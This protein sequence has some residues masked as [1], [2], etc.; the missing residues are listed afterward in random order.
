MDFQSKYQSILGDPF[1][2]DQTIKE[3]NPDLYL[4]WKLQ[5]EQLKQLLIKHDEERSVASNN[6]VY[7]QRQL[8]QRTER[9][10]DDEV[11]KSGMKLG[12]F[13][14][15]LFAMTDDMELVLD[16]GQNPD[17][18]AETY[19][20]VAS[21]LANGAKYVKDI[22]IESG[23]R[24]ALVAQALLSPSFRQS[25]PQFF[26]EV[27]VSDS[28]ES[29]HI[30][31]LQRG[32]TQ[33]Q[34]ERALSAL[35]QEEMSDEEFVA[36][37][38]N[39]L[40]RNPQLSLEPGGKSG[41]LTLEPITVMIHGLTGTRKITQFIARIDHETIRLQLQMAK[42]QTELNNAGQG[43]ATKTVNSYVQTRIVDVKTGENIETPTE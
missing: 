42:R 11:R 12:K 8:V 16:P 37:G 21:A 40:M 5:I 13:D 22:A 17:P 39:P 4:E 26:A 9:Q 43:H 35:T 23:L 14:E 36:A 20:K 30:S 6:A 33:I 15:T 27:G 1:K 32:L 34:L 3:N 25:L 18:T 10:C 19:L 41:L 2:Y 24:P 28:E 38:F 7:T 29:N 31:G